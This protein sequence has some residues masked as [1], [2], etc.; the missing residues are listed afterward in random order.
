MVAFLSRA[1]YREDTVSKTAACR[2]YNII[3]YSTESIRTKNVTGNVQCVN[4]SYTNEAEYPNDALQSELKTKQLITVSILLYL[5]TNQYEICILVVGNEY[6]NNNE[7][8]NIK[9]NCEVFE[10]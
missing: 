7:K 5:L 1:L 2:V 8:N 3:C 10:I 9:N 4:I 6:M